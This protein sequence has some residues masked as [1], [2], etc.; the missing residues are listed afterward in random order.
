MLSCVAKE[1]LQMRLH[2]RSSDGRD[3]LG[4]SWWAQHS[5]I[6]KDLMNGRGRQESQDLS[7]EQRTEMPLLAGT[8]DHIRL[9]EAGVRKTRTWIMVK[10]L[11]V[12]WKE[13]Q[14]CHHL[15]FSSQKLFQASDLHKNKVMNWSWFLAV[16]FVAVC[17]AERENWYKNESAHGYCS[18]HSWAWAL[19]NVGWMGSWHRPCTLG[20]PRLPRGWDSQVCFPSR[21]AG[22]V[23]KNSHRSAAHPTLTTVC[24]SELRAKLWIVFS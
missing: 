7:E 17:T 20:I 1:T 18:C 22:G 6:T 4:L 21:N 23:L 3:Y 10:S 5:V 13:T 16:Q 19:W 11:L 9:L 2:S 8:P 14:S 12:P 15:G 24:G